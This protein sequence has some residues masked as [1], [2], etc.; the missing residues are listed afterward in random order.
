MLLDKYLPKWDFT[1]VHHIKINATPE[2]AYRAMLDTK[3]EE[4]HWFVDFL[5][6]LRTLPEKI[7]RGRKESFDLVLPKGKS[8]LGQMLNNGFVKIEE[9]PPQEIVFGLIVP[10]AIGRVWNESSGAQISLK[11]AAEFFAF[12]DPEFLW[13]VANIAVQETDTP[14]AVIM[15]TES[16]TKGLSEKAR[17]SFQ[18]Y[19][20]IIRPWSGLIRRL[21]LKA[22]KR[23][24]E[25]ET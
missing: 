11:N 15:S 24:A 2:A 17:K 6:R 22:I 18:L 14:G 12:K 3:S 16:R 4:I 13:V 25:I 7:A 21:W 23:R 8:L 1:E 19:W 9:K 20:F 10:S 5:F